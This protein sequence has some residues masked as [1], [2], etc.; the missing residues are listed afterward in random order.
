MKIIDMAEIQ[1]VSGRGGNGAIAF[2]RE[3]YVANGGPSGGDGGRGGSVM[4]QASPELHTLLDYHYRHICK[5]GN[6]DDG[7]AKQ[8]SGK[9]GEDLI[10]KVPLGT[11][12]KDKDTGKILADMVDPDKPV[13]IAKGGRGGKG[14][15]H[16]A[17]ATYQTPRF[18]KPGT[19]GETRNLILELKTIAD[20]GLVGLPN[21]GKSSLLAA[22]SAARPKIAD[23]PFTTLQPNLGSV[24]FP[25]GDGCI[26]ADIPGL[27]EGAHT[28]I[29]LG[30]E[31]LRHIERTRLLIHLV[32][33]S[34]PTPLQDFLTIQQELHQHPAHLDQKPQLLVLNKSDLCDAE[35]IE[36]WREQ[37]A[38]HSVYPIHVI[39]ALNR[40][41]L[42][43][44]LYAI[45][46]Q[47][48]T[49]P[50][51]EP[52][53]IIEEPELLGDTETAPTYTISVEDGVFVVESP[54]LEKMAYLSDLDDS[55]ALFRF[56]KILH[57]SGLIRALAEH[58]AQP[59]DTV[60][61][62]SLEFEHL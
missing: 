1:V 5:A 52:M 35:T 60:R 33:I 40:L 45:Q 49:L 9:S 4:I 59:G 55:R 42:K 25:D 38:S 30:H 18:A 56:Q 12:I 7:G 41:D 14:N 44:L 43:P 34:A 62:G 57:R 21:A 23:Y 36:L 22:I 26:V 37:F 31:F 16:F 19:E 29:G 2:R 53:I 39:S 48:A 61:L 13:V 11:V 15:M 8:M 28:G 17:T 32:D 24:R 3:K 10:I 46:N 20:V 27:I 58:G 51:P 47:L 50:I 54:Q 6:G